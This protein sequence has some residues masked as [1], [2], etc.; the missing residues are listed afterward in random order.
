MATPRD[1]QDNDLGKKRNKDARVT[2]ICANFIAQ[3][4]LSALQSQKEGIPVDFS[5]Y[6]HDLQDMGDQ[7][8]ERRYE[9]LVN[10]KA[11]PKDYS[12]PNNAN[13]PGHLPKTTY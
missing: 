2:Q 12:S 8:I 6:Y 13:L 7:S 1:F 9:E 3:G 5:D 11:H 4:T 10:R